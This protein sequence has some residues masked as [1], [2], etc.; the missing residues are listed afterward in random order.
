MYKILIVEDDNKISSIMEEKLKKW[1]YS[2]RSISDFNNILTDFASFEP[3][4]VLMDINLPYYDG[5]YWCTKIR[6]ISNIPIIFISSRDADND[7][8]RAISHGGDD[9]IEKP[10]SM[11]LLVAK[12]Q[13]ALRRAYSYSDKALNVLEHKDM[14][15]D[16][17]RMRV[18]YNGKDIELT[19]NECRIL[20]ILV[21]NH[22]KV[23]TRTRLM[24]A[25]WDD[26]RFV[27]DNTLTVNVNR[28]RRKLE[29]AGL[30]DYIKTV[31]GEG[32]RL[33]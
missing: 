26:E 27:D 20:S 12:V 11:D 10:F 16:I 24:K 28:L 13:A 3:H 33:I 25:L 2:T 8:I 14:V 22:G 4:L 1:G 15:L 7:K 17:E 9:Y 29:T 19:P 18:F 23:V 30:K 21:R 32:Y 5:F 31:K 6:Q